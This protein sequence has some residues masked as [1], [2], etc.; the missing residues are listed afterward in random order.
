MLSSTGTAI[1][2]L[3]AASLLM[4]AGNSTPSN[5]ATATGKVTICHLNGHNGDFV[6]FRT[7]TSSTIYCDYL[8][9][10][11]IEVSQ[12]A[13]E[14]GHHAAQIFEQRSCADGDLQE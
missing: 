4:G 2:V 13:C 8:G 12:S 1:S 5:K 9:G 6:T 7:K 3:A 11:A 14:E 10:Q